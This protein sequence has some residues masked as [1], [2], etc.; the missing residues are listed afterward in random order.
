MF[1]V[2]FTESSDTEGFAHLGAFAVPLF[3]VALIAPAR[4]HAG[5]SPF[6]GSRDHFA[7]R[8]HEQAGWSKGALLVTTVAFGLFFL[9]WCYVPSRVIRGPV[10]VALGIASTVVAVAAY[11]CCWRLAPPLVR[12][13]VVGDGADHG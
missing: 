5:L 10:G 6:L 3:E 13:R 2:G 12:D 11:R 8:L 4:I 9:V 7:L 1:L